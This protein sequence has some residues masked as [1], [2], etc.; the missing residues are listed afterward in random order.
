MA[1]DLGLGKRPRNRRRP[2][3]DKSSQVQDYEPQKALGEGTLAAPLTPAPDSLTIESRRTLLACYLQCASVSLSLR[4]PNALR[5]TSHMAE[6]LNVLETSPDAAPTDRRFAAWVRIQ[7]IVED[8]VNSFSLDDPESTVSLDDIRIQGLLKGYEGQMKEWRKNLKPGVLNGFLEVNFHVNNCYLHEISLH[9]DHDPEDFR[10]PFY[11]A[12]QLISKIPTNRNPA[13]VNA[14]MECVSSAQ[15][16]LNTYIAMSAE[17][18]QSLPALIY[19][20][21]VYCCVVLIKLE[22]SS[23]APSSEL[24]NVLDSQSLKVSSYLQKCLAHQITVVGAE[25]RNIIGAKFLVIMKR[26]IGWYHSFK[27]QIASG[28]KEQPPFEP[29]GPFDPASPSNR[30]MEHAEPT[31][32]TEQKQTQSASHIAPLPDFGN[33]PANSFRPFSGIQAPPQPAQAQTFTSFN[34]PP[35]ASHQI[36]SSPSPP[37]AQ[38]QPQQQHQPYDYH[39]Q[40][41][42]ANAS[43]PASADYSSP[44]NYPPEE[45]PPTGIGSN[46]MMGSPPPGEYSKMEVDPD[47]FGQLQDMQQPFTYNPDP[48]DW[49]FDSNLADMMSGVPEFDWG[50]GEVGGMH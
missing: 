30:S 19:V 15:A 17:V 47:M 7:R 14:I 24:G 33:L 34:P 36:I 28:G 32:P 48:N 21:V 49:M 13:Y 43:S 16:V 5:F 42:A 23:N 31:A 9:P 39:A 38:L 45:Y 11:V 50:T 41:L 25:G 6:C 8:C 35:Q 46:N 20:R 40:L 3:N 37:Q 4:L 27:V 12:T 10:P 18:L 29:I 26:L 2:Q 22:I 44:E 1:L